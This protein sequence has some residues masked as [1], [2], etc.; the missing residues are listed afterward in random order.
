M[1]SIRAAQGNVSYLY[2]YNLLQSAFD[3]LVFEAVNLVH[4]LLHELRN[5]FQ[6]RILNLDNK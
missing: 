3:V 1:A 6:E 4:V 5:L 2:D